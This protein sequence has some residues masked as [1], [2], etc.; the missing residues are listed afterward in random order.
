MSNEDFIS[1]K[2]TSFSMHL[3][4]DCKVSLNHEIFMMKSIV[5]HDL[6]EHVVQPNSTDIS[7]LETAVFANKMSV[8]HGLQEVYVIPKNVEVLL[9]KQEWFENKEVYSASK[10][11]RIHSK[12]ANGYR[13]P[14]EA[15]WD[16]AMQNGLIDNNPKWE[17]VW[18]W[19]HPEYNTQDSKDPHGPSL[20]DAY[21]DP[22]EYDY[23]NSWYMNLPYTKVV[24]KCTNIQ[25]DQNLGRNNYNPSR[26]DSFTFRLVRIN[27]VF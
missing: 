24:R 1:I 6:F 19:F 5:S 23:S 15:Q 18:D 3:K 7:W 13:L 10:Q 11:V 9:S 14:T 2:P 17:W 12:S 26:R 25:E 16:Y 21:K 22:T 8:L 4:K 27:F 20:Q